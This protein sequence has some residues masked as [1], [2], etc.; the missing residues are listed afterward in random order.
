MITYNLRS[1]FER[2]FKRFQSKYLNI[3]HGS[4]VVVPPF[5]VVV[6]VVVVLFVVVVVMYTNNINSV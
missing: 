6:G 1:V 5:V 3:T 2:V 4:A